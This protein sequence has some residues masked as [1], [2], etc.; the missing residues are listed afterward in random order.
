MNILTSLA[1][2][3]KAKLDAVYL[4][5]TEGAVRIDIQAVTE[6]ARLIQTQS[7]MAQTALLGQL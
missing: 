7:I 4:S 3:M 1:T 5:E 6:A 2:A